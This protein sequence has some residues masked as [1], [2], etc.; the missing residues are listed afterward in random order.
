M[1]FQ[2][3]TKHI[4]IRLALA[5]F[6]ICINTGLAGCGAPQA[7][8]NFR[9]DVYARMTQA[10]LPPSPTPLN[11]PTRLPI[12]TKVIPPTPAL[13]S[14]G[15][16]ASAPMADLASGG[17]NI[18]IYHSQ[19]GDTLL[20]VAARFDVGPEEIK[21]PDRL[22]SP[23]LLDPGQELHIPG[24][25][26]ELPYAQP[27]LPDSEV[28]Y[29]SSADD[30][31]TAAFVQQA[32]GYLAHSLQYTTSGMTDGAGIVERVAQETSFNP[33]LLLAILEFHCGC[34]LEQPDEPPNEL[35]PLGFEF[36][37]GLYHQ[38]VWVADQLSTGYY[39]WRAGTLTQIPLPGGDTIRPDPSLNAGTVA[40]LYYFGQY[41][42]ILAEDRQTW[43]GYIDG[44]TGFPDLYMKMFGKP[45]ARAARAEP[46][47]PPAL[48]QPDLQLPF[49]TGTIWSYTGGPHFAWEK[50]GPLTAIDFAPQSAKSGC[51]PSDEWVAAS[52]AGLVVRA[53][54][55][56]I[57]LDLDGDGSE[58]TGWVLVYFHVLSEGTVELGSQ[59]KAGDMLGHPTCEEEAS[60]STGTH[61]HL[62]RKYNGEWMPARDSVK[63][64]LDGWVVHAGGQAYEGTLTKEGQTAVANPFG[65]ATS[66]V[67]RPDDIK[68]LP[69]LDS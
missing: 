56:V 49:L 32:D 33:R 62:A 14:S 69:S 10:S 12:P 45:W 37:Q 28:I 4:W 64:I 24:R 39:G 29:S 34:V 13:S 66:W 67:T 7:Y 53:E 3:I 5:L 35:Y 9:N 65:P 61:V 30:F 21:S 50:T 16:L 52:A 54:R 60:L 41:G 58:Q 51:N 15:Q 46:L 20:S 36:R 63:F 8:R 57:A 22:H 23:G 25:L 68:R 48:T 31:D 6:V 59:V 2:R 1:H 43:E 17:E 19:A 11:T 26:A 44:K 47:F 40:L 42:I 18:T 38:L 27:I 55:H